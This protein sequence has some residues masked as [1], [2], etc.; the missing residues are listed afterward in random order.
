MSPSCFA[1]Y[2]CHLTEQLGNPSIANNAKFWEEF[3]K[4]SERGSDRELAELLKRYEVDARESSGSVDRSSSEAN[5]RELG[6]VASAAPAYRMNHTAQK[7]LSKLQPNL[8]NHANDF[9]ELAKGGRAQLYAELRKNQSSWKLE[10]LRGG[11]GFSARLNNGY[12]VQ[13]SEGP[14]DSIEITHFS[15]TSTHGGH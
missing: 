10:K 6:P 8:R 1:G 5:R 9:L 14:N 7:E 15:K 4:I 12:R 2:S 11:E 3:G 13:W